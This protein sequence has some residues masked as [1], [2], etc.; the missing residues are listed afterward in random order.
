MNYFVPNF[1]VDNDIKTSQENLED[2]EQQL[3]HHWVVKPKEK[4]QPPVYFDTLANKPLDGE[5]KTSLQNLKDQE[6]IHGVWNLPE[7]K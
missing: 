3:N 5:M 7:E 6:K 2:A 4:P 1:G